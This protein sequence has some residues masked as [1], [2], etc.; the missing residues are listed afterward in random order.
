MFISFLKSIVLDDESID[1]I[2]PKLYKMQ[3]Q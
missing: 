3:G 1:T 2:V